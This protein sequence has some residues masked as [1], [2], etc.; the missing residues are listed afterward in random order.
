[1]IRNKYNLPL[2]CCSERDTNYVFRLLVSV[3]W[4][5]GTRMLFGAWEPDYATTCYM[6]LSW[7]VH[8]TGVLLFVAQ[9]Y[10]TCFSIFI[11]THLLK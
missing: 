5:L 6:C 9:I 7:E 1:V 10:F 3:L 11:R 2:L 4:V 8:I